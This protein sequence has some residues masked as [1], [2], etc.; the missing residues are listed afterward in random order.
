MVENIANINWYPG[1]M[2][3][4]KENLIRSLKLVDAVVEILDARIPRSSANPDI[5]ETIN[6]KKKIVLL[7]KSDLADDIQTKKWIDFFKQQ[8]IL[9]LK[10]D[11][12][13]GKGIKNFYNS[14]QNYL[15]DIKDKWNQ[16]GQTGRKLKLMVVGIPNVGKSSFINKV[17]KNSKA[18]AENKP[19]VTKQ[20]QWYNVNNNL[21]LLDT[22]GLLWPKLE[23]KE[24]SVN[25]SFVGSIRDEI[26]D[27]EELAVQLLET[28]KN[29]YLNKIALRYNLDI[30]AMKG[31]AG[32]E[33]LEEIAKSRK[34]IIA[35]GNLDLSRAGNILINEYRSGKLGKIT[36]EQV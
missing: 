7:N 18:K 19:G 4:T 34:F 2:K 5:N 31:L 20:N 28:L 14:I 30:N 6:N 9:A 15:K 24:V 12:K 13:T 10:V 1:H 35:G 32:Y 33:M 21:E 29:N 36:L 23:N 27:T 3:K 11:C 22:P 25:L 17:S 16:K 26:M 8:G